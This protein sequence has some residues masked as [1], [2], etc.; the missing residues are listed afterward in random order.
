MWPDAFICDTTHSYVTWHTH[1]W[2]DSST[3]GMTHSYM[4]AFI[5]DMTHSYVDMTPHTWHLSL[6]CDM[7]HSY[8]TWLIHKWH[9]SY[10]C[11]M[12]HS[13]LTRPTEN[14]MS[15]PSRTLQG[16]KYESIWM[17]AGAKDHDSFIRGT[18]DR[19]F[20]AWWNLSKVSS[21][22]IAYG[23]WINMNECGCEGSWLIHVW[24]N[25]RE[26]CCRWNF[27]KVSS[28]VSAHVV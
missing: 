18:N 13:Y 6:I 8:V 1:M 26:I 22:D 15:D 5:L 11:D 27:W 25:S 17:G 20:A 2:H 16:V 4:T 24:H 19:K 3:C 7:T 21:I 9:D 23:I 14:L 10:T 12:T 28:I